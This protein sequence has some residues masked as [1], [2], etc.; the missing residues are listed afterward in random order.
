MTNR[1]GLLGTLRRLF[2]PAGRTAAQGSPEA[3]PL[4]AG[5]EPGRGGPNATVEIVP[6]PPDG[7][8]LSYAPEVD[9]DP[10]AGEIIWTWVP[11]DE[12]DGRGKDRPV[13]IVGRQDE[14]W[15]YG[16]RLTSKS[17][18]GDRDFFAIGTGRWDAQAR[19]SWVDV[20]QLYRVHHSGM[21]REASVL[22]L[23]RFVRVADVLHRRYG[24]AVTGPRDSRA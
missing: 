10:D 13:L 7:L 2:R 19:P 15:V 5:L 23:D 12:N 4:S 16:V 21:R 6:P 3:V 11:Y 9:G 1:A 8:Q 18:D 24:W 20:E 14:E 17:H 22:D